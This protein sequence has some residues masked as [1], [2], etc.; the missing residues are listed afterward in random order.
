MQGNY[1]NKIFFSGEA[2]FTLEGYINNE[3]CRFWGSEK[4]QVIE[5]RP[6]QPRKVTV[7]C[8][9]WSDLTILIRKLRWYD[10]HRQFEA[11]WSYGNRLFCLLLKNA[12]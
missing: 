3:N 2:H 8:A 7:W 5:E 11:L 10:C 1:S 4:P 9:L 6:L 12:T